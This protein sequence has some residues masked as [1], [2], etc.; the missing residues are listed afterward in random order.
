MILPKIGITLGDPGGIGPEI[1][2][3]AFCRETSLPTAHY[4]LFGSSSIL[5]E[6][7]NGLGF[8][9][10]IQ[11]WDNFAEARISDPPSIFLVEVE[12]P[13]KSIRKGSPSRENGLA[14]FHFFEAA[15][16]E[17]RRGKIQ[18]LVTAPISKKSWNLAGIKWNGHTDFLGQF[19]PQAIMTFW[20]EK[21]R[22]ALFSHHLSLRKALEKIKKDK[23]LQFLLFLDK[24]LK[25]IN[26][27][28]FEFL[29][30][31]LNPHAGEEGILGC[32]EE[33]EIIPAIKEAEEKG[34]KISGPFPP[35]IIFRHALDNP[36]RIVVALYHDQGLIAFKLLAFEEGVNITLGLPF[37][38][39]SPDHGTAFD[40][41]GKNRANPQSMIEAI[42][43]AYELSPSS[44]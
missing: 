10:N 43:L 4:V 34:M 22:L 31:G 12:H 19:Y 26:P 15:F 18:A 37:I 23:L 5:E 14:S 25:R 24:A 7:E 33:E 44:F 6:E 42:K 36:R 16:E 39:T 40:I 41:A 29:V 35:D 32:E 1:I 21:I 28:E 3:K 30:S 2:L 13:L 17:A 38:R 9:L 20:S 27:G 8:K 11:H